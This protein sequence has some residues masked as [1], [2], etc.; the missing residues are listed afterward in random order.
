[1]MLV[2]VC[3]GFAVVQSALTDNGVSLMIAFAALAGS[4][5]SEFLL[6]FKLRSQ[7]VFD[8][9]AVASALVFT[10]LL[11]NTFPPLLAFLGS[12]FAMAV[13]KYSFGGLGG[14]WVNPAIGAWLFARFSWPTAFGETLKNSPF[15]APPPPL[16]LNGVNA[17]G[18]LSPD[19]VSLAELSPAAGT[20]EAGV[21]DFLNRTLFPLFDAYLPQE[22]ASLFAPRFPAII[23]DRGLLGL[24]AGTVV[25]IAF[26][27]AKAWTP[28][29]FLGV[30]ALLV[31]IFGSALLG[32]ALGNG[33]IFF[34]VCSG[35]V[36]AAAFL[37]N[38]DPVTAPKSRSG[39]AATTVLAAALAFVFRYL[40]SEPCGAF[41][42]AALV[43]V[44]VPL[45]RDAESRLLYHAE[46]SHG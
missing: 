32:G 3:A 39:K 34:G 46:G 26:Q 2:S 38:A 10:L 8:G 27:A 23:A 31:R 36:I 25:I 18:V 20:W 5:A 4:V 7:T 37:I 12:I 24:L 44:L 1:M 15:L 33:N 41:F 40:G 22:Y 21:I 43:N 28:V 42:A 13:V 45:I 6:N 14:N 9:S 16:A 19:A 35:G 29:V 11:P 17:G 30:Y